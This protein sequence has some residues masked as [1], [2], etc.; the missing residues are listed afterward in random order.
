[1][2]RELLMTCALVM[3]RGPAMMKPAPTPRSMLP[4]FHGTL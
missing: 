4:G 2:K 3:M 1:M